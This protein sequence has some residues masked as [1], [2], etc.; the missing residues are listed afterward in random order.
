VNAARDTAPYRPFRTIGYLLASALVFLVVWLPLAFVTGGFT[1]GPPE[2]VRFS[3]LEEAQRKAFSNYGAAW[4]GSHVEAR[5]T[6]TGY[7]IDRRWLWWTEVSLPVDAKLST[8]TARSSLAP[9][10]PSSTFSLQ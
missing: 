6:S 4:P 9:A 5:P 2:N 8:N 10:T 3:S 1:M 7:V